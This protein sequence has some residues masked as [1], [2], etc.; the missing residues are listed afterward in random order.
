MAADDPP[1]PPGP[2]GADPSA[3]RAGPPYLLGLRL[4]GRR[5]V[6]AGGGRVADRRVPVL[7]RA[8]ADVVVISPSVTVGLEG[9]AVAGQISWERRR[10][11]P[12]DLDGAW[13]V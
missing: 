8:G 4:S 5:V 6:V 13:L 2:A 12:G 9:L 11:A 1:L 3:G 7:V 10:Y